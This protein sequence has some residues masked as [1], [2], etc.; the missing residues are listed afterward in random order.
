MKYINKC[1]M[2]VWPVGHCAKFNQSVIASANSSAIASGNLSTTES[3][4]AIV[5]LCLVYCVRRAKVADKL[6]KRKY[7]PPPPCPLP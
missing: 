3:V 6:L 5:P 7:L 4:N 1:E 2:K